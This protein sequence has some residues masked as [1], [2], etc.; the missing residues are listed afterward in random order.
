MQRFILDNLQDLQQ[1]HTNVHEANTIRK[2]WSL[3]L[4]LYSSLLPK[5]LVETVFEIAFESYFETASETASETTIEETLLTQLDSGI[6]FRP[7]LSR[8]K[9]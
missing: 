1:I 6:F 7:Y 9:V 3:M 4:T 5:I 8:I 2:L